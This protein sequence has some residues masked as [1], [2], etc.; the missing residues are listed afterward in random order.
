L[1]TQIGRTYHEIL[2][3]SESD[4]NAIRNAKKYFKLS[5]KLA[6]DYKRGNPQL[7]KSSYLK[8]KHL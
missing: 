2:L 1:H 5:M 7:E 6:K 4:H 3:C 8:D